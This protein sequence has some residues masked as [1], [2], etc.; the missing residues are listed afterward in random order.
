MLTMLPQ[1]FASGPVQIIST[2]FGFTN[3]KGHGKHTNTKRMRHT[4]TYIFL[5]PACRVFPDRPQ[6][7]LHP[8]GGAGFSEWSDRGEVG[9]GGCFPIVYPFTINKVMTIIKW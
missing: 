7:I 8:K 1:G 3:K 9:G 5:F 2:K 4:F 6:N